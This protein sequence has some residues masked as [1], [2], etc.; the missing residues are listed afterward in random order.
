M[1]KFSE[2]NVGSE[3][4]KQTVDKMKEDYNKLALNHLNKKDLNDAVTQ[5]HADLTIM[6]GKVKEKVT[7]L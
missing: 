1:R 3:A 5:M 4:L 2:A 7:H 6:Q